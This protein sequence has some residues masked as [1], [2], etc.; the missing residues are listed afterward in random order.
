MKKSYVING[1][2][3]QPRQDGSSNGNIGQHSV[4]VG[5]DGTTW[6]SPVQYGTFLNDKTTKST[7][8]SNI[9]ARYVRITAQT[10]A[11]GANNPWSS[12]ADLNI[13]SPDMNLNAATFIPPPTSM[14]RWESTLVLPIVPVAG[15]L[16]PEGHLIFVSPPV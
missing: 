3:Y 16:S 7:F 14:G 6:S 8:F 5:N 12:I 15:T 1:I 13:L 4:T 2:S 10:E 11:Q 9:T